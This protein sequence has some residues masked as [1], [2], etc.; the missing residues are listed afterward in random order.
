MAVYRAAVLR[1]FGRPF[2]IEEYSYEPPGGW[3]GVR[4]RA[5]GVCGRDVVVWR[6][7]FRN[8]RPPLVLGHE[9]FGEYDGKPV[10]VFPAIVGEECRERMPGRENLCRDYA[11]LGETVP[12]GYAEQVYV[13]RWNLIELPDTRYTDY[14]AAACGVATFIHAARVAG[15]GAGDRVIVTGA[16]GGVGIHGVQY[17]LSHGVEVY[18]TTRSREKARVL[19]ELGVH[20]LTSR[21]F[22]RELGAKVDAVFEV[23]GA[24]TINESLRALRPQG[25]LVLIG[26]VEGKPLELVRPAMIVMRELRITGSAAYTRREYEAAISLIARGLVRPFYK[27][28]RLDEVN[29]AYE[30][31]LA[32]RLVGR[33]VIIP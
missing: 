22:S 4:V 29:Q 21:E 17:L 15:V 10:A 20:P 13:P 26:N 3:I 28:Y 25:T 2:S 12:G 14:A 5:V 1:G 24:P 6:G 32:G 23:V 9:V 7:G 11:I 31:I 30:N 19:E 27:T 18:G 8:L 16:A 33:A